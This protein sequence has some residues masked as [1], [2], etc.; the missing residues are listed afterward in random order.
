MVQAMLTI[1]F[2]DTII[3]GDLS[4]PLDPGRND[5]LQSLQNMINNDKFTKFEEKN[6][7][8]VHFQKR[9]IQEDYVRRNHTSYLSRAAPM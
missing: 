7:N 5:N 1:Y 3:Q 2:L 9:F 6:G 4:D 8:K